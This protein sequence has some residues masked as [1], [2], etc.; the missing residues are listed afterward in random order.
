MLGTTRA[1]FCVA[2][3]FLN[4]W[5]SKHCKQEKKHGITGKTGQKSAT[6]ACSFK[7]AVRKGYMEGTG[8][9]ED[10]Q[11][12]AGWVQTPGTTGSRSTMSWRVVLLQTYVFTAD[13]EHC[14]VLAPFLAAEDLVQMVFLW[15]VLISS[16]ELDSQE[17]WL[18]QFQADVKD[19]V[20]ILEPEGVSACVRSWAN[21]EA[22]RLTRRLLA[23]GEDGDK[24]LVE[25]W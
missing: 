19:E 6:C 15:V 12:R 13:S 8:V 20:G 21:L 16:Q 11:R 24:H 9:L 2:L 23:S 22:E 4:F 10:I 25:V 14:Y 3:I 1:T 5:R 18:Q 17:N 7:S